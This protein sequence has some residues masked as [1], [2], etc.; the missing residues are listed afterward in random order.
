[1]SIE[2]GVYFFKLVSFL[3]FLGFIVFIWCL[4]LG[5]LGGLNK[6]VCGECI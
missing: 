3:V 6:I 1:M 2:C 4:F 5:V